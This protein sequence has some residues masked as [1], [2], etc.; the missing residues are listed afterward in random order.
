MAMQGIVAAMNLRRGMV[1]IETNGYGYTII[2]L[3]SG[4]DIQVGDQM[5]WANDTGMGSETYHNITKGTQMDVFV[6]N[7]WVPKRQLKQQLLIR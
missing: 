4:E 2:E 1:A 7:H 6:Q 5:A 3:L